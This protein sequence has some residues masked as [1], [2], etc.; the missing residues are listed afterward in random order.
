MRPSLLYGRSACSRSSPSSHLTL[1]EDVVGGFSQLDRA[2]AGV[3]LPLK[4]QFEVCYIDS[5]TQRW[6]SHRQLSHQE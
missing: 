3:I 4:R 1:S 2:F 5:P 6:L